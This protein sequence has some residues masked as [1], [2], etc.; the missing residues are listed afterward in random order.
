MYVLTE[1][2]SEQDLTAI[3]EKL[4][5]LIEVPCVTGVG[6]A[7]IETVVSP[8]IGIAV[9]PRHGETPEALIKSADSAMYRAK[10]SRFGFSFAR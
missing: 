7:M 2:E 3:A 6:D 1:Y 10:R 9:F 4:I 5:A 8:S